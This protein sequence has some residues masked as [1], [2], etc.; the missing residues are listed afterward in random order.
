M[1]PQLIKVE[2]ARANTFPAGF[3][4]SVESP[5]GMH[6]LKEQK[7][8]HTPAQTSN[9]SIFAWHRGRQINLATEVEPL[10]RKYPGVLSAACLC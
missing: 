6:L 4:T 10:L 9:V 7:R 5:A 1:P 3:N 2:Q 8:D